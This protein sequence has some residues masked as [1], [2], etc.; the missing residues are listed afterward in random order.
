MD[1][2]IKT[3]TEQAFDDSQFNSYVIDPYL[4]TV[5]AE[6]RSGVEFSDTRTGGGRTKL[7]QKRLFKLLPSTLLWERKTLE[8]FT[9][10]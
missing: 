6:S 3:F 9:S 8:T 5:S 2:A 7:I 10:S 1:D 4:T